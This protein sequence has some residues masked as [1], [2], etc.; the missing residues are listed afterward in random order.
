MQTGENKSYNEKEKIKIDS[1][2]LTNNWKT[3]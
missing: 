3:K 2:K 1:K